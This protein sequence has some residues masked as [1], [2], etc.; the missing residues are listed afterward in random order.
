MG[1]FGKSAVLILLLAVSTPLLYR[2]F[3]TDKTVSFMSNYYSNYKVIDQFLRQSAGHIDTAKNYLPDSQQVKDVVGNLNKRLTSFIESVKT[4]DKSKVN[5]EKD[6]TSENVHRMSSCPGEDLQIR[7]W[8]KEELLK[9]D[10]HSDPQILLAFLG[11][12]YNVTLGAQHYGPGAEYNVFAGRDATRAFVTGNFTHDLHDDIRDIDEEMYTHIESW[13]SFYGT[14]YPVVGR[15]EGQFFDSRGCGTSELGRIYQ[16][17]GKLADKK[18]SQKEQDKSLPECNSE[19]NGDLKSGRV[20]CTTKSG[21]I[22]RDWVG[23]PRLYND[24][25][26]ERCVC[27]DV[28]SPEAKNLEKTLKRYTGCDPNSTECPIKQ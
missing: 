19:W 23:V 22:E 18:A 2:Q 25:Q 10:G 5:N 7:L 20:W 9:Y 26:S 11:L 8:S 17:F 3:A 1:L 21:G 12:V 15:I 4:D 14:S 24:G 27:L 28:S 16:V 6:K 13:A